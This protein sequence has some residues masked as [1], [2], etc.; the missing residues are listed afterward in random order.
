MIVKAGEVLPAELAACRWIETLVFEDFDQDALP[1][2]VGELVN[3]RR[4][5]LKQATKLARLPRCIFALPRLTHL[6]LSGSGISDLDGIEHAPSLRRVSIPDTPIGV[7]EQ[8]REALRARFA[9]STVSSSYGP[10][11]ILVPREV[12]PLPEDKAALLE[13]IRAEALDQRASLNGADLSGATFEDLRLSVD[14]LKHANLAGTTWRR[15]ELSTHLDGTNLEGAVFED[16]LLPAPM[17]GV[18][19]RNAVFDRCS[20]P[21]TSMA[22]ANLC[23]ARLRGVRPGSTLDLEKAEAR[24][25][26][27]EVLI[28]DLMYAKHFVGPKADL[29]GATITFELTPEARAA[30]EHSPDPKAAWPKNAFKGAKTDAATRIEYAPLPGAK[31]ATPAARVAKTSGARPIGRIDAPNA[32]LWFLAIDATAAAGWKGDHDR[33][34]A[35]LEAGELVLTVGKAK[36][37][38]CEVSDRGWSYIWRIDGGVALLDHHANDGVAGDDLAEALAERVATLPAHGA[39][40]HLGSVAVKSGALALLLPH[41]SGAFTADERREAAGGDEAVEVDEGR[42]LVPLAKGTYDIFVDSLGAPPYEDALGR[43]VSRLRIA[44]KK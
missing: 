31:P 5:S 33:A 9:K 28:G 17:V 2:L 25:L 20:F 36:G 26:V 11:E 27:L 22:K 1:E 44:K 4:L 42:V 14:E 34:M 7:D 32:A 16:C 38:L 37:V 6:D 24:D 13:A 12:L 10:F 40:I 15:C 29:Q 39:P 41:T 3:L 19:A 43:Y 35:A 18:Q 8:R 21:M 30:L 23:G